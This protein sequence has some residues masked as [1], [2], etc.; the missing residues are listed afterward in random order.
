MNTRGTQGAVATTNLE[1]VSMMQTARDVP[2]TGSINAV[3]QRI[4]PQ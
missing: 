2:I 4:Q 1:A 3:T